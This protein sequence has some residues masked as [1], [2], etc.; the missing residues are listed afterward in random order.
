MTIIPNVILALDL[1]SL[2]KTF[3]AKTAKD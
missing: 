1:R 3:T 2:T